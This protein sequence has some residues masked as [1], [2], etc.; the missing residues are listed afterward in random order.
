MVAIS[1]NP[2]SVKK[3]HRFIARTTSRIVDL[4]LS[5]SRRATAGFPFEKTHISLRLRSG[6]LFSLAIETKTGQLLIYP[7]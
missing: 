1:H 5:Q 3:P 6:V 4:Q 2:V 7:T